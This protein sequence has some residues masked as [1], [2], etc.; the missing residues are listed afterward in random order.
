[1]IGDQYKRENVVRRNGAPFR[2]R[3]I[4]PSSSSGFVAAASR[5]SCSTASSVRSIDLIDDAFFGRL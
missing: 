2:P 4:S 1:M 3:N 5:P